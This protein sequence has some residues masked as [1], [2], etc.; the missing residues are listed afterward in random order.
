MEQ[1][2][3]IV[4]LCKYCQSAGHRALSRVTKAEPIVALKGLDENQGFLTYAR[5]QMNLAIEFHR[6]TSMLF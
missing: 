4:K 5:I 1:Y 6:Q 2:I 3:A